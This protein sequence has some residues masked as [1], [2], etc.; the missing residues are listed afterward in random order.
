MKIA[1]L[2]PPFFFVL[3]KKNVP[4]TV[5]EKGAFVPFG[6]VKGYDSG[7]PQTLPTK[8]GSL[9]P[10]ASDPGSPGERSAAKVSLGWKWVDANLKGPRV[11]A[12]G[13]SLRYALLLGLTFTTQVCA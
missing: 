11:L 5:E 7:S 4:C 3:S 13:V 2:H 10:G 9:L 8:S 12:P 6:S 1:A